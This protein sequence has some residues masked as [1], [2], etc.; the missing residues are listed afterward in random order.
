MKVSYLK[1]I[2]SSMKKKGGNV[3]WLGDKSTSLIARIGRGW[4]GYMER[5]MMI[6]I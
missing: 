1:G 5:C 6:L 2:K 3:I 4:G